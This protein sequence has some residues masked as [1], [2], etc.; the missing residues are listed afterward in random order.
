MSVALSSSTP[1]TGGSTWTLV[2]RPLLLMLLLGYGVSLIASGRFTLRLVVDGALSFAFVPLCEFA[3]L[4]VVYRLRRPTLSFAEAVDRFFA[5]N[6]PW[7]WWFLGVLI[8][9]AVLPVRQHG[10]LLPALLVAAVLPIV[11]SVF[12]DVRFFR[13]VM[14]STRGQARLDVTLQRVIS[15]SAA[16][17]YFLGL[18]ITSRD[19]LYLFVEMWEQIVWSVKEFAS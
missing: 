3:G 16:T 15:W 7:L 12:I 4:A 11:L 13:D 6:T 8:A 5:G 1:A 17:A 19:F 2:R 10:H 14:G 9:A 18:A